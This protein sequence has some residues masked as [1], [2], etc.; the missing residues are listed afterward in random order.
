M[1]KRLLSNIIMAVSIVMIVI[2]I[3]GAAPHIYGY[4]QGDSTYKNMEQ[5][6][7]D[8]SIEETTT[9]EQETVNH[10]DED[11]NAKKE[12]QT[13]KKEL[14]PV[15]NHWPSVDF[16]ALSN[17]NSDVKAWIK[18]EGTKINYP[19][20]QGSDNDFY[21]NHMVNKKQNAAGSIFWDYENKTDFSDV[22][23][24]IYG[25]HMKNGSM[26]AGLQSYDSQDYYEVHPTGMLVLPNQKYEIRFV[27]AYVANVND[28]AWQMDFSDQAGIDKW[29]N[30]AI[31]KST[32]KS[33]YSVKPGDHFVTLS[34]C[35]YE[36]DDARYILV[37]VVKPV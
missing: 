18:I 31:K 22:N 32:F 21:L 5:F 37:G 29:I 23:T 25:H 12:E 4:L 2:G 7:K 33:H 3:A 19:V 35:S 20:V 8:E 14:T 17:I 9:I 16:S 6:V 13:T 36:F 11:A 28:N 27:A 1:S 24:I 10:A 26:F 30:S 15:V 34:T